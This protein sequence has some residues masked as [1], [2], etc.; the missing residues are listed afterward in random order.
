[1][2][3]DNKIVKRIRITFVVGFIVAFASTSA[4]AVLI[5]ETFEGPYLGDRVSLEDGV[6][7]NYEVSSSLQFI[8][9]GQAFSTVVDVTGNKALNV[10]G[11][12]SGLGVLR[13]NF[14]GGAVWGFSVDVS[15]GTDPVIIEGY[16]AGDVF[17]GESAEGGTSPLPSYQTLYFNSTAIP[18]LPLSC[19]HAQGVPMGTARSGRSIS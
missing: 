3:E 17:L 9:G 4:S 13:L 5:V 8:T 14:L 18:Q 1:M 6:V 19:A 12:P 16:G 7:F 11:A 10:L 15:D 2:I